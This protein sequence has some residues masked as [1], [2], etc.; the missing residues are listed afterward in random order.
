MAH[1]QCAGSCKQEHSSF[2]THRQQGLTSP[3]RNGTPSRSAPWRAR[4]GASSGT[5]TTRPSGV[6]ETTTIPFLAA[7]LLVCILEAVAGFLLWGGYKSG[8][9]LA[10]VLL[11]VGGV[12]WWGFAL[13]IP[14]I[15]ALAWAILIFL[16]WQTLR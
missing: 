4:S 14:P 3:S 6:K 15:F 11:P 7:F 5:S 12:F 8:A 16:G 10:L 1:V 9:D 2:S 13:P